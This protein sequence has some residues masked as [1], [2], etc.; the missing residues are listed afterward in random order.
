MKRC[1]H[2]VSMALFASATA[3]STGQGDGGVVGP[4][5]PEAK[6]LPD[7]A[8]AGSPGR[9]VDAPPP[10]PTREGRGAPGFIDACLVPGMTRAT[11]HP[12]G[13]IDA[14]GE[15]VTAALELPFPFTACGTSHTRYW[16]TTHGRLGFGKV[17]GDAGSGQA[18]CPLPDS[19]FAKPLLLVYSTDLGRRL[20][21]AAG[22]CHATTGAAPRRK[23]VVTWQDAVFY[24]GWLT[25]KVTFSATLNEGT[26]VLDV[27]L[28]RVGAPYQAF[29]ETGGAA[30]LGK[31][32]GEWA[33]AFSWFQAFTPEGTV[34]HYNP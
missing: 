21:P 8:P 28:E 13:S 18:T 2:A 27:Q 12:A 16:F 30:A 19:R 26:N 31:Q 15:R 11:F 25:A 14:T 24:D 17:P 7:T 6:P 3:C 29:F 23:L 10:V 32:A 20:G 22:V 9:S 5:G 33:H 34:I 1:K 4:A